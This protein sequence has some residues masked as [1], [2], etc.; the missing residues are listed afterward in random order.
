MFSKW[1]ECGLG[2]DPGLERE[3]AGERAERR[4][5]G[6]VEDDPLLAGE[7]LLDHVAVDAAAAVVEELQRAGHLFPDRDRHDRRDDQLAVRVLEA[8]PAGGA[9][10]LEEHAV[11]QPGVLLQ[12]DEP[13]AIDPEDLADVVLGAGWPCSCGARGSR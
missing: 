9:D 1:L 4:E 5:V 13:V 3:P 11:D 12:V 8:G 10:V 7:L 6:R 2:D